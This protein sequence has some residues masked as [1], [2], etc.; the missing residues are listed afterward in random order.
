MNEFLLDLALLEHLDLGIAVIGAD[1][2]LRAVNK[3]LRVALIQTNGDDLAFTGS[4]LLTALGITTA[5]DPNQ[6]QDTQ[7]SE[8]NEQMLRVIRRRITIH[9]ENLILVQVQDLTSERRKNNAL[10]QYTSD[11]LLKV[12]SRITPIQNALTLILD[13][14]DNMSK[15]ESNFLLGIS[16]LEIWQLERWLDS[17]RDFSL[18]NSGTLSFKLQSDSLCLLEQIQKAT[19]YLQQTLKHGN[20]K[21]T[22][23][24]NIDPS[25]RVFVDQ[26]R[27]T[28]IIE[29]LLINSIDYCSTEPIIEIG[30]SVHGNRVSIFIKDNGIGITNAEQPHIFEYGFRASNAV[31]NN[32]SGLGTDLWFS[33]NLLSR[34]DGRI[35]FESTQQGTTFL[36]D[37]PIAP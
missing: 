16:S 20:R 28:R 25:I 3:P 14:P 15:D 1:D 33:R 21:F 22:N 19:S 24:I 17:L 7:I 10:H 37:L 32:V 12:R 26:A 29:G 2:S 8:K 11:L 23:V 34:M 27:F 5:F 9:E 6:I 31:V 36:I 18:L 4:D 30:A 13:Y 35:E